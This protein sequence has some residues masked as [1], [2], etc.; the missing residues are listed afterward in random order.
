[1]EMEEATRKLELALDQVKLARKGEQDAEQKRQNFTNYIFHEIRVPLN[2]IVL[3]TNYLEE[4]SSFTE[5]ITKD[6]LD[7]FNRIIQGLG[8]I[9]V[10][11]ND[12]LDFG[13]MTEGRFQI[14]LKPFNFYTMVSNL[15]WSMQETWKAKNQTL[16]MDYD[17]VLKDI[18]VL[19]I[20][21]ENRV[22][23][24]ISNYLSNAV[25]F[26][27]LGGVIHFSVQ[28]KS[29]LTSSVVLY[30]QVR[31]NGI[32]IS[33]E[34]QLKLFQPF[35]QIMATKGDSTKG[36]GLGLA[37]CAGLVTQLKGKYGLSSVLA[38]GSTFWFEIPLYMST[39]PVTEVEV[40]PERKSNSVPGKLSVLVTDDEPN[41]R[42]I[43]SKI[44]QRIGYSVDTAIDGIDCLEKLEKSTYDVLFIDNLMPRLSGLETIKRIRETNTKLKI[45]SLTASAQIET[46]NTLRSAGADK[47][48][49]K[50]CTR[51]VLE[52]VLSEFVLT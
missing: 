51:F 45:V 30:V 39:I 16:I 20:S 22:R 38:Q 15:I 34:N 18:P 27:P 37:I 10:I 33:P 48:I 43:M 3:S 26:T 50:P 19:L 23:Q 25:K 44:I 41:T 21:D 6:Q 31:D 5:R 46:Q 1:M 52:T 2:T 8:S 36:T 11:L 14:S 35:V 29:T 9:E 28:L 7:I 49:I 42:L 17:Q 47:V 12:T 13:K 4:D 40:V 32:G 24:I